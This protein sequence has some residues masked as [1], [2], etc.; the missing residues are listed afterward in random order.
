MVENMYC[1]YCGNVIK[2]EGK[3]CSQCGKKAGQRKEPS[4]GS[5][6]IQKAESLHLEDKEILEGQ[7]EGIRSGS[8][9]DE[10][11]EA[12][13]AGK[14]YP[15][16]SVKKLLFSKKI[17]KE[18]TLEKCEPLDDGLKTYNYW[19]ILLCLLF[20]CNGRSFESVFMG[21]LVAWVIKTV[22]AGFRW[23]YL[24]MVKYRVRQQ[25]SQDELFEHLVLALAPYG[26][27]VENK[28]NAIK[29]IEGGMQYKVYYESDSFFKMIPRAFLI[30]E[31]LQIGI[32]SKYRRAI[33]D[34]GI[35]GYCITDICSGAGQNLMGMEVV[36]AKNWYFVE[37]KKGCISTIIG[38]VLGLAI[39]IVLAFET[40][41]VDK[42][43]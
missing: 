43:V 25:I 21:I 5:P 1:A 13:K 26:M 14:D 42:I 15:E 37:R 30:Q 10:R 17:E 23:E 32:I 34:L 40:G 19:Y 35:I 4:R 6:E 12:S 22:I 36:L 16:G 18:A 20:L 31:M 39:I 11:E 33:I 9:N 3:F 8:R 41:V 27:L 2:E 24:K 28:K 29:I 7:R 38:I